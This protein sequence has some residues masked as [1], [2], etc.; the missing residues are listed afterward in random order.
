M[1]RGTMS[2]TLLRPGTLG[3]MMA[4]LLA[5]NMSTVAAQ[6]MA[7]SALFTRNVSSTETRRDRCRPGQSGRAT[8]V[9]ILSIGVIAAANME[10][11]FTQI[12][13]LLTVQVPFG[14]A[15]MLMF[16]WRRLT[17]AAVWTTV[18]VSS[19]L[20]I[21]APKFAENIDGWRTSQAFVAQGNEAGVKTPVF[22]DAL[23]HQQPND[24]AS[25]LEA[26]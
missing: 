6:T 25:P 12:Q 9:V 26:R 21:V 13:L 7:V 18:I 17:A 22:W 20:N 24:L 2:L 1:P 4:G 8:I 19:L 15:V 3:L 11:V 10:D 5:A 14:A 16:F 23:V